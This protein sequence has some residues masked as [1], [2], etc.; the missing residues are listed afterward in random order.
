MDHASP[1]RSQSVNSD[2]GQ[3]KTTGRA[4]DSDGRQRQTKSTGRAIDGD[5]RQTH[6][7]D[8]PSNQRRLEL[9]TNSDGGTRE[10]QS[11]GEVDRGA[12]RHTNSV[13]ECDSRSSSA[14]ADARERAGNASTQR[15]GEGGATQKENGGLVLCRGDG[16]DCMSVAASKWTVEQVGAWLGSIG[17]PMH[18]AMFADSAI[19][20]DML[21]S[22]TDEDLSDL[23]VSSPRDR[24]IILRRSAKLRISL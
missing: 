19:D 18:T 4:I 23:N 6:G 9:L 5:G 10:G 15:E 3:A 13:S 8:T 2:G 22:L 24:R 16:A 14:A 1:Q 7:D 17:M 21:L 20:G 12:G 11:G